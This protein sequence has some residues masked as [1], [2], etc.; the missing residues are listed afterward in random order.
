[1]LRANAA[2][3]GLSKRLEVR[4]EDFRE[5]TMRPINGATL[6]VGNPPYVRHHGIGKE[7]KVWFAQAAH[8]RGFNASKLAGLHIHF[9]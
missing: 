2:V 3:L 8:E 4:L 5:T 9:F 1:V 6:F 7:W